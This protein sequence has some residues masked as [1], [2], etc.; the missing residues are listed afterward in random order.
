MKEI[1]KIYQE[2]LQCLM[3]A[4]IN[5]INTNALY[6]NANLDKILIKIKASIKLMQK[7]IKKLEK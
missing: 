4:E 3:L 6:G 2:N 1:L 5:I 7:E